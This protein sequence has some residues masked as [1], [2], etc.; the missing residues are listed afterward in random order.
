VT[1]KLEKLLT[2]ECV[3]LTEQLLSLFWFKHVIRKYTEVI[4][5]YNTSSSDVT[6]KE[7]FTTPKHIN[8]I[9]ELKLF[10]VLISEEKLIYSAIYYR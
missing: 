10:N 7:R 2:L 3:Q 9:H 4:A 1:V 6:Y 5:M 8:V